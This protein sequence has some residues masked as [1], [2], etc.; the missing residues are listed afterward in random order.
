M[1]VPGLIT[2][3]HRI[4]QGTPETTLPVRIFLTLEWGHAAVR[5]GH[6]LGPIIGGV[7][8]NRIIGDFQVVQL[9]QDL[10][11]MSIGFYHAVC[12][13]SQ[14]GFSF[15]R[16]LKVRPDVHTGCVEPDEEWFVRAVGAV[17]EVEGRFQK[18]LIH[19]FHPFGGEGARV[20]HL[21]V[22][23]RLEHP[24]RAEPLP[25]GRVPRVVRMLRLLLGVHVV[26]VPK[27]FIEAVVRGQEL[28]LVTQ[29][30][31]QTGLSCN[32]GLRAVRLWSGLG[33]MPMS[34]PGKPTLVSPVRNGVWPVMKAALPAV[35]LCWP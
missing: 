31:L 17:D 15:R 35:Q 20:F 33:R 21:P 24:P 12:V 19:C 23:S 28:I 13:D 8:N 22:R 26:E 4:T 16:R 29:M 14:S 2:P 32:P 6:D 1:I 34:A 25:E 10:A 3:G 27:E 7:N 18:L 9:L 30:I 11:Y 5:P